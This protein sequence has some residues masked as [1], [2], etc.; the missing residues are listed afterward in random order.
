MDS[1]LKYKEKY[2]ILGK[3]CYPAVFMT[4]NVFS[5]KSMEKGSQ[6]QRQK[7]MKERKWQRYR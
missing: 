7:G 4:E 1:F 5:I 6:K 3:D 2:C